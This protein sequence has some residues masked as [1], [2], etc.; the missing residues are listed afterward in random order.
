[1]IILE[2]TELPP[3]INHTYFISRRSLY[4]TK[5]AKDWQEVATYITKSK[6]K[7]FK[8]S[9]WYG[10]YML[11]TLNSNRRDVDSMVK[12]VQDSIADGLGINDN[13]I[14]IFTVKKE[15]K[16]GQNQSIKVWFMSYEE[17]ISTPCPLL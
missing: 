3:T 4:K 15:I 12:L 13:R 17:F 8:E 14:K 6:K 9:D 11:V 10:Y 1:M 16:K 2:F 7:D 5:V